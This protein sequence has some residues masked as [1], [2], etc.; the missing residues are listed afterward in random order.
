M[1]IEKRGKSKALFLLLNSIKPAFFFP[2]GK[3]VHLLDA[4]LD[5]YQQ[6]YAQK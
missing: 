5:K 1:L 4:L 2:F 3:N 6:M